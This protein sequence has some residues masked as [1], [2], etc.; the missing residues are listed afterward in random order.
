MSVVLEASRQLICVLPAA[1][2]LM[3]THPALGPKGVIVESSRE[4]V[5][6]APKS[7]ILCSACGTV[8]LLHA[9]CMPYRVQVHAYC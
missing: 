3:K 9:T 2:G 6:P 4:R 8:E 7:K 5:S 1:S